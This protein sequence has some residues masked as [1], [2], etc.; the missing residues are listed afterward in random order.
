M[1]I[2]EDLEANIEA[3][4]IDQ[5]KGAHGM[6]ETELQGFVDVFRGG[7]SGFKHVESFVA[8]ERVDARGDE[9]GS[10]I[11]QDDFLAHAPS[12]FSAGS[13]G[14]FG[15]M[16]R[17]DEFDEL[18]FRDG[19]KEVHAN[20]AVARH[21]DVR[22]LGDGQGGSVACEYSAGLGEL[23]ED[24]EEFE[25]HFQLFRDGLDDEIGIA[26]VIFDVARRSNQPQRLVADAPFHFPSRNTFFEG[27]PNPRDTLFEHVARNVFKHRLV[28]A[29][30]GGVSDSPPHRAGADHRNG[31]HIHSSLSTRQ[32]VT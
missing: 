8:D 24:G 25:L 11:D 31:L 30:S 12:D 10:L 21:S 14:F 7:D 1:E 22:E 2:L 16:R 13:N 3:D 23:V 29:E 32:D 9:T 19:I 4:E 27:L 28:A 18:H 20:A 6:I 15:S 5:L 26:D 17:P